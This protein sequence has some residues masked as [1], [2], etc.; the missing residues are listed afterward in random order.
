MMS[1]ANSLEIR[2]PFLDQEVVDFAFGL[3]VEYKINSRMKKR[4]VQDAFRNLLP[5]ELY[6]RPKQGFDV[7]LLQ[8]FRRE[9]WNRIDENLLADRFIEEQGLFDLAFVKSLKKQLHSTNP[10]DSHET[11]WALIVFQ[12]WWRK[13]FQA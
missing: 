1:M 7:P 4:I 2:S 9:L 6:N 11:V 10:G 8:W 5:V 12:H 3:P 13:T